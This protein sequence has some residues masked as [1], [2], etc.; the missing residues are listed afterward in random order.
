VGRI[1]ANDGSQWI[2]PADTLFGTAP[3]VPDLYNEC[4]SV[5]PSGTGDV[6]IAA[7]PVV[8][9]GGAEEFVAYLFGDN[10]FGFYA[11]GV[12]L[13]VDAVPFTPFNS[14]VMRFRAGRPVTF[15]VKMVDKE[16]NLGLGS[17]AG[18]GAAYSPG[19][20][21]LTMLITDASG[22]P[23]LL[24]DEQWKAQTYYIS[25]LGDHACL[26]LSG[27]VRDSAACEILRSDDGT[28]YSAAHWPLPDNWT[29]PAFDD[30]AWPN[31]VAYSNE[32]VGVNNKP[33][34]ENFPDLFDRTGVDA[35]FIWSFNLILDNLVLLRRTLN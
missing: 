27:P 24:T 1:V 34:F 30:S 14:S 3:L 15:A 16:E 2:V 25:P 6:D 7:L 12:L 29:A 10:Y 23:V 32:T 22:A 19:D 18:R 28:G 33:A 13:G 26:D 17:E 4:V 8:D 9:A 11:N 21:G 31:A 35:K 5:T 20:G